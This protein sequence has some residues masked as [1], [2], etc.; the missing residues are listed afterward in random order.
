MSQRHPSVAPQPERGDSNGDVLQHMVDHPDPDRGTVHTPGEITQQPEMWR[1]TARLVRDRAP[2]LKR[3]LEAAGLY[4]DEIP[5]RILLT[6]AGTSH[7]VGLSV[8]DL[9]RRRFDTPCESRPTTRI[10]PNP[11]LF[12]RE[13]EPTLMVHFAR[14]GNSP[15]SRAVLEGGLECMGEAGRHLVITCNS[16]GTLAELARAHPDR[17]HLLVLPDDTND[18]GLAMTSSYTSMVVASQA[19]AHLD[20]MDAF[21]HQTDRTAEIEETDHLSV[22]AYDAEG[23]VPALQ[24]TNV[25]VLIGQMAGLFAAYRRGVNVDEPSVEKALY[26]RTVQ[27]VQI[28]DPSGACAENSGEHR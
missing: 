10:T 11:D 15:E 9:L 25:A 12:F 5:S 18:Q 20:R 3:F 16:D 17:V 7:Y 22:F 13:G 19:L 27:G 24:Q 26:N 21:V 1:Q 23:E 6:G 4:S 28:Y 8:V 2:A 14:S